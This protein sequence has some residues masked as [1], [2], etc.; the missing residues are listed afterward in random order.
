[1]GPILCLNLLDFLYLSP[2]GIRK[3]KIDFSIISSMNHETYVQHFLSQLSNLFISMFQ[4]THRIR[5]S[6]RI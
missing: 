6:S 2:L 3:D 5:S 1:M 4:N